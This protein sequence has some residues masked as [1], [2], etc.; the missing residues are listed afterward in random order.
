MMGFLS[1]VYMICSVCTNLVFFG[2]FFTLTL[3]YCFVAGANWQI[4]NGNTALAGRL[5]AAAGAVFFVSVSLGWWI[6][7][8]IM[9]ASLDFPFQV[10]VGD[11]STLSMPMSERMKKKE[12]EV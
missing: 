3:G 6:F 4:A 10:P 2:I 8:A 5:Q 11:L 7:F 12:H 9:L 1:F